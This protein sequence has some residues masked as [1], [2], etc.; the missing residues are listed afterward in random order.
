MGNVSNVQR[1]YGCLFRA[2][3]MPVRFSDFFNTDNSDSVREAIILSNLLDRQVC[4]SAYKGS[5][6][7][8]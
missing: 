8:K 5:T 7:I 3:E 6:I 4:P 1:D 2:E